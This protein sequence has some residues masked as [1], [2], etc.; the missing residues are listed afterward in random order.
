MI[1]I[2]KSLRRL[3]LQ[4]SGK[5]L[6]SCPV[7]LGSEPVG[8][9]T[10]EGDGRT[11]EGS[12]YI[13]T[14]NRSSKFCISLGISYPSPADAK[15]GLKRSELGYFDYLLICLAALFRLRPKWTS[16]LGGYVMI[17]GESPEGRTG[18]WTQGCVALSDSDIKALSALVG[19]GEKVRILP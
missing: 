12:Y 17:H 5:E 1:V 6:F 18:D 10:R 16:P 15:G 3:T 11:P 14:V 9:K 4:R 7:S 2:E 13:C 8:A 19:K